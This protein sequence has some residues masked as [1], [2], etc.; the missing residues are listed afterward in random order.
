M[1]AAYLDAHHF[2]DAGGP[3][4]TRRKKDLAEAALPE[5]PLE[6]DTEAAFRD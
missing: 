3:P 5:E 4:Q 6:C 2:G 1:C